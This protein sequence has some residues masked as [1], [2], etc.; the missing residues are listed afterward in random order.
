M[1]P[2]LPISD[3]VGDPDEVQDPPKEATKIIGLGCQG[4]DEAEGYQV[5]DLPED[6][7]GVNLITEGREY[8]MGH[9][10][11]KGGS[12]NNRAIFR[13]RG[14]GVHVRKEKV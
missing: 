8:K 1:S 6:H 4:G 3:P 13:V 10:H 14:I 2:T 5:V 7:L 11:V 9:P 12:G